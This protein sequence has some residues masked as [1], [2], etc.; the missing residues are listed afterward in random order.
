MATAGRNTGAKKVRRKAKKNVVAA[1]EKVAERLGNTKAVCRKCYIHPAVLNAYLDGSM[2]QTLK[3]RAADMAR[4]MSKL[5]PEE[6][7][8]LAL[9]QRRLAQTN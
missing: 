1:V 7:A 9:I 4:S 3:Q 2:V 6:A 8:V 5:R